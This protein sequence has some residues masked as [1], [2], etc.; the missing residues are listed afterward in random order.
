MR[1]I[2]GFIAV[3]AR[4]GQGLPPDDALALLQE[5]VEWQQAGGRSLGDPFAL[6]GFLGFSAAG[7]LAQVRWSLVERY[8]DWGP[9][10]YCEASEGSKWTP[11]PK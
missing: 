2:A 7:R 10:T 1:R 9:R 8:V 3:I 6:D 4:A 5:A 11:T